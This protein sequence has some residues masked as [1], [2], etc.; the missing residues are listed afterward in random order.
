VL[1]S[2]CV[3][4]HLPGKRCRWEVQEVGMD[5]PACFA[6]G[7]S[8]FESMLCVRRLFRLQRQ[9]DEGKLVW[10]GFVEVVDA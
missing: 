10:H 8:R 2:F 6:D 5:F 1:P 9:A 7:G 3:S 4:E